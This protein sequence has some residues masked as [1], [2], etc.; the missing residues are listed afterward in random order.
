MTVMD[1][2]GISVQ[3][4]D[5]HQYPLPP[6]RGGFEPR[7]DG[8]GRYV[9]PHPSTGRP[10]SYTRV[11][12]V[13]KITDDTYGLDLWKRRL[14]TRGLIEHP[15]VFSGSN[16]EALT[17]RECNGLAESA[18][19]LAGGVEAAEFG[20][21]V[22]AWLHAIDAGLTLPALV[23]PMFREHA[24]C[25][26]HALAR[27]AIAIPPTMCE[28]IVM[29]RKEPE[30]LVGTLDRI[31]VMADGSLVLGD[32]KTSKS[33]EYS[34][35]SF[36]AQLTAYRDADL[37]LSEDGTRWEPMPELNEDYALLMHCPSDRPEATA[38]IPFSLAVGR[39][40]LA[41]SMKIRR[42]R[43]TAKTSV[44]N[45]ATLPIPDAVTAQR[46]RAIAAMRNITDPVE[47]QPIWEA[48]RNVWTDDLTTLGHAVAQQLS[49]GPLV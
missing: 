45:C 36:A 10:T 8:Y 4:T 14:T 27:N 39:E 32:I 9:L 23:P 31:V 20:T 34:Y 33:L 37:M 43:S 7:Y 46:H 24:H 48:H 18:F 47:L 3:G 5:F 22:H 29:Y 38:A 1:E 35:L 16:I 49:E 25:H 13:A 44:P 6:K 17:D 15:E 26:L 41:M 19:K 40:V 11:S 30:P 2:R 12:T 42:M 28:R 21:A